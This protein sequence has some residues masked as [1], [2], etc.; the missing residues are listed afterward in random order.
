MSNIPADTISKSNV[1]GSWTQALLLEGSPGPAEAV[2][3]RCF[4]AVK[5]RG[6]Y[7]P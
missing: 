4:F 7:G 2:D 5:K 3:L 1:A 6:C